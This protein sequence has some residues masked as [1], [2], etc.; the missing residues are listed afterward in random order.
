MKSKVFALF[1]RSKAIFLC[2]FIKIKNPVKIKLM[3][4][5]RKYNFYI[6]LCWF[7]R[8]SIA[9][10]NI[11]YSNPLVKD[12]FKY[13][14]ENSES[15]DTPASILMNLSVHNIDSTNR[16]ELGFC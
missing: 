5:S 2:E 4:C 14:F 15:E 7:L 11:C 16:A 8:T 12:V 9:S 1:D 6:I 13:Y 3:I 10:A